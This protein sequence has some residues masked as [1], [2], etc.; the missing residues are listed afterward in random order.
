MSGATPP[1]TFTRR[2]FTPATLI[3]AVRATFAIWGDNEQTPSKMATAN[4]AWMNLKPLPALRVIRSTTAL[5]ALGSELPRVSA[6]SK[7]GMRGE[8]Q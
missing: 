1:S 7:V 5:G 3:T 4:A 6:A 8:I 2:S